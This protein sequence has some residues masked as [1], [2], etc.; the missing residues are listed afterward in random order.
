MRKAIIVVGAVILL[1]ASLA[2]AQL[3]P[4]DPTKGSRLFVNKGCVR[5]H[6]LKGDGGKIG[7]DFGRVDFGNTQIDLA[8]K[9]WNHI[10]SMNIGM[11]QARMIKPNL[12]GQ[13]FT[14]ISAYLYFLKFFDEPGDATRGRSIFNE[15]GCSSCHPLSGK[16]KEGEPGLDQFPQN[17]SPV[18]LTQSIWNHG[19][20]MIAHMVKLGMKWPVFEGTEMMDLLDYIKVNA[21]GAK[22]T[23]FITPGNPKEGKQVFAAKGCIK[24]HAVRGEGGKEAEDLGKRAKTFY[25]S[26]T[27]ITSIMW[28]KGPAVLGK[29]SQTQ[30]G[31]PKFTP[32]EMADLI[33]YLYFLHF[34][35]EPGNPVNGKKIFSESGC[36]KCHGVDGKP[37]ELMTLSLS[38][39]QKAGNSMDIVASLWNHSTE[40]EKAMKGKGISWPRFKKG[41]LADLLEFIRTP[42]KK[43]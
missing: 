12:T 14:E 8:A 39:Y 33:A 24:C 34:I 25:K 13:E 38:K 31:I 41:E 16:G 18:F 32:K 26:L 42:K 3:L 15:K 36:S 22:E 10:P 35:D 29:M 40:I 30:I 27:Q 43:P 7:P 19:P 20:V 1:I 6:A 37:G 2:F 23:A 9:L 4:E 11:E 28:N 17:I 21:K 5:C